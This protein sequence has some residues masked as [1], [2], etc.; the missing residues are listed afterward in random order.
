MP[1][2][3]VVINI[4]Y[5]PWTVDQGDRLDRLGPLAGYLALYCWLNIIGE[6]PSIY[7]GCWGV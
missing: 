4:T 5:D 1:R 2:S 6:S 7:L 3:R